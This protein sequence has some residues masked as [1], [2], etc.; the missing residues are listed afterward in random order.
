MKL[1]TILTDAKK[2]VGALTTIEATAVGLG[3]LDNADAGYVTAVLG[4]VTAAVVYLLD[5]TENGKPKSAP[6]STPPAV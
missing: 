1:A 6:T 4:A 5:N 3:V 2:A